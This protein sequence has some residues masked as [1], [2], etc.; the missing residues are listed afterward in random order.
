MYATKNITKCNL[1]ND[2]V[3]IM[4]SFIFLG[5]SIENTREISEEIKGC[6]E[7]VRYGKTKIY[8]QPR[9]PELWTPWYSH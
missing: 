2:E 1:E 3:V 5:T 6:G 8:R 7:T 9:K 4:G